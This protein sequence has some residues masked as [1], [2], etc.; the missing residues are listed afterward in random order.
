M[1]EILKVAITGPESTGKSS[2]AE[3]LAAHFNTVWVPEFARN[4]INQLN[5]PYEQD[6]ILQI[7]LGQL[8]EEKRWGTNANRILFCDTEFTVTKIWSDVKYGQCDPRIFQLM[9]EH[10]YDLYLLCDIDLPWEPDPQREHPH[11]RAHL[12]NL[13]QHELTLHQ[14][15]FKLVSGLGT[16]RLKN[17]IKI[18]EKSLI[19]S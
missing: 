17:A 18:I 7:A 3:G 8:E 14:K 2:L 4:Y 9:V 11:M 5:R 16:D 12:L 10:H 1:S 6:D 13:Y 19:I 15:P